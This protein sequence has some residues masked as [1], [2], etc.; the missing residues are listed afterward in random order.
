[1]SGFGR[2]EHSRLLDLFMNGVEGNRN[3]LQSAETGAIIT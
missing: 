2:P 3:A 1:M